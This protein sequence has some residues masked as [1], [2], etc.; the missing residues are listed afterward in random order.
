MRI[1]TGVPVAAKLVYGRSW[2]AGGVM[3]GPDYLSQRWQTVMRTQFDLRPCRQSGSVQLRFGSDSAALRR[4]R[5]NCEI[6]PRAVKLALSGPR[7]LG[8][9][10]PAS[11]AFHS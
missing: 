10:A 6:L 1:S 5:Q 3:K 11:N 4:P 7:E 9:Q 8:G 2:L